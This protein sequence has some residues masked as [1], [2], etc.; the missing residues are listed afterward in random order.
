M[1]N[2][3]HPAIMG[4]IQELPSSGVVWES[5]A[6]EAWLQA[7]GAILV[8]VYP[9]RCTCAEYGSRSCPEHQN[10]GELFMTGYAE[11]AA[12]AR[13]AVLVRV[14]VALNEL[15]QWAANLKTRNLMPAPKSDGSV[16]A[17]LDRA[18]ALERDSIVVDSA[19]G[20]AVN[21]RTGQRFTTKRDRA[22]RRILRLTPGQN[23]VQINNASGGDLSIIIRHRDAWN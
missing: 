10:G 12:R 22:R 17:A 3:V 8:V 20:I 4:L 16:E 13:E 6:R 21:A 7:L 15:G 23:F 18:L 1:S 2:G 5:S 19:S 11:N 9:D 14:A